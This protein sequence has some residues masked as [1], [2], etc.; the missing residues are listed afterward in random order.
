LTIG[1]WIFWAL[2]CR[3][4]DCA[5]SFAVLILQCPFRMKRGDT[6]ENGPTSC[7]RKWKSLFVN[8]ARAISLLP[9]LPLFFLGCANPGPDK[10]P[11]NAQATPTPP[12]MQS[13]NNDKTVATGSANDKAILVYH[14]QPGNGKPL[15]SAQATQL[16]TLLANN[17]AAAIYAC[18]PFHYGQPATFADG[19]WRWRQTVPGDY[20]AIVYVAVDGSTNRVI[21]NLLNST[22]IPAP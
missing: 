18:Q 19:R 17:K 15:T 3:I 21:V 4:S 13:V 9:I 14:C 11:V 10:P 20:E 8:S 2:R 6:V 16:A 7:G 1:C 5:I 22:G 12:A